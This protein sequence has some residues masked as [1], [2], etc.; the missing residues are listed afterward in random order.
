[1]VTG[2]FF[3]LSDGRQRRGRD[4]KHEEREGNGQREQKLGWKQGHCHYVIYAL[5]IR[6]LRLPGQTLLRE[7]DDD[8]LFFFYVLI[9]MEKAAVLQ[10]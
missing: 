9:C 4:R 2:V 8:F 1:M 10:R 6:R 7:V 3:P 5:T